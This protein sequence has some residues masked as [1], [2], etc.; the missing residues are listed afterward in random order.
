MIE[1]SF[2]LSPRQQKWVFIF[3]QRCCRTFESLHF[4]GPAPFPAWALLGLSAFVL[5]GCHPSA[6]SANT[7]WLC[8]GVSTGMRWWSW[9]NPWHEAEATLPGYRGCLEGNHLLLHVWSEVNPNIPGGATRCRFFF[10]SSLFWGFAVFKA[11]SPLLSPP[12]PGTSGSCKCLR[13]S[14]WPGAR[15]QPPPKSQWCL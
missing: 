7:A 5:H 15:R 11:S 9:E 14:W 2:P 3:H 6:P 1:F 12:S 13:A 10:F 4:S 8:R